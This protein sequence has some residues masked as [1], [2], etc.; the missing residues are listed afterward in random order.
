MRPVHF[1]LIGALTLGAAFTGAALVH[2]G[3]LDGLTQ[4]LL[5]GL[6]SSAPDTSA[7]ATVGDSEAA[8]RAPSG[9]PA[10][11]ALDELGKAE[12]AYDAGRFDSAVTFFGVARMML[13]DPAQHARAASG[14]ER[15]VL[16]CSVLAGSPRTSLSPEAARTEFDRLKQQAESVPNEQNW[17]AASRFA[18][19]AG[20]V[21]E[22]PYVV[23]RCLQSA[24]RGGPVEAQLRQGLSGPRRGQ[25]VKALL[26]R[27]LDATLPTATVAATSTET[28][29]GSHGDGTD[30]GPSG[31]GNVGHAP[32][33]STVPFGSF[34]TKMRERLRRAIQL[35]QR[36][37]EQYELARP[38]SADRKQHRHDAM[39]LLK[40]AREIL[41]DALEADPESRG[42]ESHLQEVNKMLS[43]LKKDSLLDE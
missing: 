27:G 31:I 43:F 17:L 3:G 21:A 38:G 7:E 12:R 4:D 35:E 13:E 36:G 28:P 29:N 16:A 22:T 42:V 6:V 8:P 33:S 26:A 9:D 10:L 5:D 37:R 24:V 32:L 11:D 23:E 2:P 40:Q 34:D 20:L 14:L 15:A 25:L 39:E 1:L 18:A 41:V 30:D 19:G